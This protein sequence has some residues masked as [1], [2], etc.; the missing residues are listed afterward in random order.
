MLEAM[1]YAT[2][3][4]DVSYEDDST[5][6]LQDYL[7]QL[8]SHEDALFVLSGTMGNLLGIRSLLTQPPYGIISDSRSHFLTTEAG[9]TFAFTGVVA[10][11]VLPSNGLYLTLEDILPHVKINPGRNVHMVPT[12]VITLENTFRGIIMPLSETRRI[13]EFAHQ[14][15]IKVHL[16]GA[17]LWEAVTAGA[18]S[19][20]ARISLLKEYCSLFDTVTMC[21]SKGL[22]AP[23]GS[24][25]VGSS[26]IIQQARWFR[27]SIGGGMRQPGPLTACAYTAV[28]E[29]FEAGR[30]ENPQKLAREIAEFWVTKCQG[31]LVYPTDTNMFWPDLS[32]QRFTLD[33]LRIEGQKRGLRISRERLVLH[34]R[35][36][37]TSKHIRNIR[38]DYSNR[39][40]K[41]GC[42]L[43]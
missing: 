27:Q 29:T 26:A 34:Y 2:L 38:A 24:I 28:K 18:Q 12:R 15:G 22:G 5:N 11:P 35:K 20:E 13:C 31:K 3:G 17:R 6:A 33:D 4:N 40:I 14:N 7:A 1:T 23:A 32:N 8:T 19:P 16:D 37:C 43:T 42:K 9:G 36:F 39:N 21:F 30:L 10:Q 25:L 41:R